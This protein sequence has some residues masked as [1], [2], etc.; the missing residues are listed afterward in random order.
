MIIIHDAPLWYYVTFGVLLMLLIG[1]FWVIPIIINYF[2][3]HYKMS[4]GKRFK[5]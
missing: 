4:N 2:D 5:K 1:A 3:R